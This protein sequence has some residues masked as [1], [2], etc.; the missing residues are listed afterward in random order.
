[1]QPL[2]VT[3]R[4]GAGLRRAADLARRG[5]VVEA[6]APSDGKAAAGAPA[7]GGSGSGIS[8]L[9]VVGSVG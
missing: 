3:A 2:Q 9:G 1:M 8:V 7:P 4:R 5:R 6:A